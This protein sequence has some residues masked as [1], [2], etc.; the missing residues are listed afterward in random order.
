MKWGNWLIGACCALF[1]AVIVT[2]TGF[3]EGVWRLATGKD[4]AAWV[5]AYG[6]IG[7]IVTSVMA[8]WWL[9]NREKRID[10]EAKDLAALE[11]LFV[12]AISTTTVIGQARKRSHNRGWTR[13]MV[14]FTERKFEV[15][16]ES[17]RAF[18]LS[19]L[20]TRLAKTKLTALRMAILASEASL[21][22]V[23]DALDEEKTP[24]ATGFDGPFGVALEA[25]DTLATMVPSAG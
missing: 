9:Q 14:A 23:S 24:S 2:P 10:R 7:A 6:S 4:A 25:R 13:K 1:V 8:A 18:D 12:I 21:G 5:Q 17:I 22:A 19:S 20:P 15:E 16:M 3:Y 11:T